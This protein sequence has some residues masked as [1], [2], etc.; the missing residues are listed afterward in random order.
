MSLLV[1][2]F[3]FSI[4]KYY[5]ISKLIFFIY[6]PNIIDNCEIKIILTEIGNKL[7]N[8]G[9]FK[10]TFIEFIKKGDTRKNNCTAMIDTIMGPFRYY[11]N[12]LIRTIT[13]YTFL[14]SIV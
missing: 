12:K 1:T 9:A 4:Y 14:C 6:T 11:L 13:F 8:V 10:Y 2:P 3:Y 7:A 5:R